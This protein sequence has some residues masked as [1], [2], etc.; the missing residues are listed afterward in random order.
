MVIRLKISTILWTILTLPLFPL[1]LLPWIIKK[2]EEEDLD[3]VYVPAA[4]LTVF[5]SL[6]VG[7]IY[8][9]SM[10]GESSVIEVNPPLGISVEEGTKF[11]VTVDYHCM[12]SFLPWSWSYQKTYVR[13]ESLD[14]DDAYWIDPETEEAF[15]NYW[16]EAEFK[17]LVTQLVPTKRIKL[18]LAE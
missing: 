10:F 5:A 3:C 7:V 12:I 16:W 2:A 11:E 17:Y 9:M 15:I 1:T 6:A 8:I 13:W 14:T 4:L 18:I